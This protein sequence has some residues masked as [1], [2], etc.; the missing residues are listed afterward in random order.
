[1]FPNVPPGMNIASEKNPFQRNRNIRKDHQPHTGHIATNK[2]ITAT[3]PTTA[4]IDTNLGL[5]SSMFFASEI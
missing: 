4:P 5:Y 2:D 1:M 3:R